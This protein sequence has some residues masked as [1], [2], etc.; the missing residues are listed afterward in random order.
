MSFFLLRHLTDL[1][2]LTSLRNKVKALLQQILLAFLPSSLTTIH[3]MRLNR[4]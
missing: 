3:W 4:E 2:H 1:R